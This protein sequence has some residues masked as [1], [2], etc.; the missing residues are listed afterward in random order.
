MR[1]EKKYVV[2]GFFTFDGMKMQE[3][4]VD[5]QVSFSSSMLSFEKKSDFFG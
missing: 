2:F 1:Y 3:T 5:G 4:N